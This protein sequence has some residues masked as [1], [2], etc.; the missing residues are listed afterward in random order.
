MSQT[1][2]SSPASDSPTTGLSGWERLGEDI[3][4]RPLYYSILAVVAAAL[5]AAALLG[6]QYF[7]SSDIEAVNERTAAFAE[8]LQADTPAEVVTQLEEVASSMEGTPTEQPF[9]YELIRYNKLAGDQSTSQADKLRFY[10]GAVSAAETLKSKHPKSLWATMSARPS[11]GPQAPK[12]PS[13]V[14]SVIEY[15]QGQIS[16]LEQHPY[17][18]DENPD[19]NLTV[20]L[21]LEEPGD[22]GEEATKHTMRIQC[23]SQA[24]PQ[25]VDA[26]LQLV[27]N[28]YFVGTLLSG[29]ERKFQTE[30][31]QLVH[32][33]SAFSKVVPDD[34]SLWNADGDNIGVSINNEPNYLK[35]TAGRIVLD[36]FNASGGS[37]PS[38][39]I[40]FLEDAPTWERRDVFAQVHEDD[41]DILEKLKAVE[42][43]T[44]DAGANTWGKKFIPLKPWKITAAAVTGQPAHPPARTLKL[45][46]QLPK[47]P[48]KDDK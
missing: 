30:D 20:T 43:D 32:F 16:W 18:L 14:D 47:K 19:P 21:T 5:I 24:A 40:L 46:V 42:V 2:T 41:R 38:R 29:M 36:R 6:F 10:R 35:A 39:F 11:T 25:A 27:N 23:F 45:E 9:Y 17:Q 12:A 15:C 33:G 13:L 8:A 34:S 7:R 26:F 1:S 37:D 31:P 28:G 22:E 44:S 48:E 3:R 4:Q